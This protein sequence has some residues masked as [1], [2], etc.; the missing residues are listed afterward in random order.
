M[1]AIQCRQMFCLVCVAQEIGKNSNETYSFEMGRWRGSCQLW[2]ERLGGFVLEEIT[3]PTSVHTLCGKERKQKRMHGRSFSSTHPRMPV[4]PACVDAEVPSSKLYQCHRNSRALRTTLSCLT[5]MWSFPVTPM[6]SVQDP[7]LGRVYTASPTLLVRAAGE[8]LHF[9]R[10]VSI[11][12]HASSWNNAC[13]ECLQS[14]VKRIVSN[15]FQLTEELHWC[16]TKPR[17]W[18]DRTAW[19]FE[20][21]QVYDNIESTSENWKPCGH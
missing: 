2:C 1:Q 9:Y 19:Q 6:G 13:T 17:V 14:T 15:C 5:Q 12:C 7:F 3:L 10:L 21:I 8:R 20:L 11:L 18:T 4:T 16:R